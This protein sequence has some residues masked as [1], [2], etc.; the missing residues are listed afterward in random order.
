MKIMQLWKRFFISCLLLV[1]IAS[2]ATAEREIPNPPTSTPTFV[3]ASPTMVPPTKTIIFRTATPNPASCEEVEGICLELTFDGESCTYAGPT[4]ITTGPVLLL[5]LNKSEGTAAA[6]LVRHKGD[7]TI[8]DMIDFIGEEPSTKHHPSWTVEIRGVYRSV[9][10]GAS[11]VWEGD[12]EP[13]IYSM[14]CARL[15]PLGVWFGTGLTVE[16]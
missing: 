8:R 13:G 5:F 1:Q 3:L 7:E 9:K 15:V 6:N 11:H 14:V 12:L 10:S 16:E 2:C 4:I